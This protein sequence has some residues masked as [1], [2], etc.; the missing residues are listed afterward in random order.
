MKSMPV[1]VALLCALG[2]FAQAGDVPRPNI[3]LMMGDD[4]GWEETGYNGHPHVKTP[5]LKLMG[6][7]ATRDFVNFRHETIAEHDYL[8]ARAIID[9]RFKLV[10]HDQRD[11]VV[12]RELFDL[13][14][15]PA[16][17]HDLVD[18]LSDVATTLQARLAQ[19]QQSVLRSLTGA[20]YLE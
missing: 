1:L 8:G 12:K 16:E 19:W 7:K 10:I 2:G 18:Q 15:D 5:V 14:A 3:I 20:D 11:G 17:E 9:G 13:R 6:G 4:H